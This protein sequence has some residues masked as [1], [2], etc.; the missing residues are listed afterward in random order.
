MTP[1]QGTV[2]WTELMTRD[3]EAAKRYYETICGWQFTDVPMGP[4]GPIY[5]LGMQGDQPV[6]GMM[7][8]ADSGEPAEVAP[9]WMSYF[10]V[11]DVDGAVSDVTAAGGTILRPPFDVPGTGRIAIVIDPTGA[12]HGLMTPEPMPAE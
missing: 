3:V 8:M 9:Y 4:D 6:I 10:A 2:A 12:L 5:I 1:T 11:P 7:D